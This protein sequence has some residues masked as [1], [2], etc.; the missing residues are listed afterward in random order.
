MDFTDLPKRHAAAEL[1]RS[2]LHNRPLDQFLTWI[3]EAKS[4]GICEYNAMALSTATTSGTPSSRIVLL[5]QI[6]EG[7][8]YFFTN[9]TSRK[10]RDLQENPQAAALFFWPAQMRQVHVEGTVEEISAE[11][12]N[13]YFAKRPRGSQLGAWVSLQGERIPDKKFLI[14]ELQ[15][16]EIRYAGHPIPRPPHWGGYR[17]IPKRYEFWQ[18]GENRLHDRFEYVLEGGQWKISRL[19]P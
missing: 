3:D 13:A 9:Y 17:L 8:L 10:A 16:A 18:G 1:K 6:D 15:Q 19:S 11:E 4:A 5:K 7:G 2:D 12:S 14:G